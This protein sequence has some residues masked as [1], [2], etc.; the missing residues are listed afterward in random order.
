MIN[1]QVKF[2]VECLFPGSFFAEEDSMT[3]EEFNAN[4]PLAGCFAYQFYSVTTKAVDVNDEHFSKSKRIDIGGKV[5]P[6]GK[7]YTADQIR[8]EFPGHDILIDN[9]RAN[10][11]PTVVLTRRGN[12]QPFNE[13]DKIE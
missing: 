12:W 4:G 9:M 5:Y 3:L 11:W 2:Y 7:L 1:E 10:N 8:A 6:G 13:G